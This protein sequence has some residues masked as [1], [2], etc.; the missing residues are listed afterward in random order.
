MRSYAQNGEDLVLSGALE[1]GGRG[2][3]VDV[4]ASEPVLGSVTHHFYRRGWRGVNVEPKADI[5]ARLVR[6]RPDDVNLQVALGRE[7]GRLT[8]H[9]FEVE[10]ISTLAAASARHFIEL[11]H[12]CRPHDVEVL[13]LRQVCE[14]HCPGPID[15]MKVDVEGWEREVLEGGDWRRFRPRVVVVEAIRP[16]TAEA[17]WAEWEP[18]LLSQGYHL[19]YFDGL[20]RYYVSDEARALLGRFPPRWAGALHRLAFRALLA[21]WPLLAR[22]LRLPLH[23]R[24]P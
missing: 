19:A 15:F 10:G 2:W 13:T 11:G 23:L 8:F 5:H 7:Q 20:N 3:Y 18:F 14:A 17:C 24:R 16:G 21:G 22:L 6:A 9:E 1:P 12:A 4:G